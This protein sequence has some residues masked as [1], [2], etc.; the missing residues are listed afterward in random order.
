VAG[1]DFLLIAAGLPMALRKVPPNP[2][3][4]VR[5]PETM[6]SPEVWYDVNAWG[7]SILMGVGVVSIAASAIGYRFA[8]DDA[9]AGWIYFAAIMVPLFAAVV[10]ILAL[11]SWRARR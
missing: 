9:Q 5:L 3:Y 10:A 1:S 2:I 6:R 8:E 4:G 11:A 7:G